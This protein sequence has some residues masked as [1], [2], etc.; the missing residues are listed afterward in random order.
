MTDAIE[1]H[2]LV[3]RFPRHRGYRELL[4]H[5]RRRAETEALRGITLSVERG[6]VFGLLGPNGAGKS[7]LIR[8][9][10]TLVLPTE[11]SA[12]VDGHDVVRDA[13]AVRR[14]MGYV[15]AD[16]RSFYWRLTGRQNLR[17]FA[18]LNNMVGREAERR[19][20]EVAD[21]VGLLRDLDRPFLHY[22]T[23]T[24]QKM[25]IARGLLTDPSVLLLDEPTRSLDLPA[26]QA[27]REFVKAELVGRGRTV[28]IATHNMDE[29][30]E[31]CGRVAVIDRGLLRAC[32]T[33]TELVAGAA[34][35]RTRVL[36]EVEGCSDETM[37]RLRGLCPVDGLRITAETKQP[38]G[39]GLGHA[40]A[41]EIV[42]Q[43]E[44]PST[45]D[46][47]DNVVYS[48]ARITSIR[49]EAPSLAEVFLQIVGE[50]TDGQI[51][52]E[53]TDGERSEVAGAESSGSGAQYPK[54]SDP[55]DDERGPVAEPPAESPGPVSTGAQR[56]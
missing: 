11:G 10:C 39:G 54:E 32:G 34:S 31:L 37:R 30:V 25:A 47:I 38:L 51:A 55:C 20:E 3:K 17:F 43:G 36:L 44:L 40:V 42:R 22:S 50:Q 8:I 15:V 14:R 21:L 24:K 18:T 33:P 13:A 6:E 28:L 49:E 48:G 56:R 27:M 26:A 2:D 29:A 16:E 7:T 4:R 19:L 12:S 52:G 23:G 41:L 5:P 46:V 45:A 53:Q 1:L 9:L 35:A